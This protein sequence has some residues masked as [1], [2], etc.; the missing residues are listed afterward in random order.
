[1]LNEIQYSHASFFVYSSYKCV[2]KKYA[3]GEPEKDDSDLPIGFI[4][5]NQ[6]TKH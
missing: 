1:M 3:A 2:L 5:V 6:F 4:R